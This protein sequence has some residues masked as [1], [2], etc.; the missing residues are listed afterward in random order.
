MLGTERPSEMHHTNDW[1]ISEGVNVG[2]NELED[3]L[4]LGEVLGRE[5]VFGAIGRVAGSYTS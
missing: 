4:A 2:R 1:R 5:L 3:S